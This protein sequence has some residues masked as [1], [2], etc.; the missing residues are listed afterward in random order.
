M[1]NID[2]IRINL[3]PYFFVALIPVIA[4]TV[5]VYR[6]T[7][8]QVNKTFKI[9]LTALRAIA[10]TL[11]LFFL[12]EP[13]VGVSRKLVN[14]PVNLVFVDDS[15]SIQIDDKTN[16]KEKL[17]GFVNDAVSS[18][19]MNHS[20]FFRFGNKIKPVSADSVK[21]L[22][23]S[24]PVTNFSNLFSSIKNYQ[25][26][27]SSIIIISDGVITDGVNPV[28]QAQKTGAPVFTVG[29]GDSTRKNNL[30]I[31]KV[32]MNEYIYA[33]TP[34]SINL[35]I[36]NYGFKNQTVTL[37]F[38]EDNKLLEKQ[39]VTLTGEEISSI[40]F[41]YLPKNPGEKKLTFQLSDLK[42]ESSTADNKKVIYVN[43]LNNKIR[44]LVIAGSPSA[45]LSF[46]KQTL[47]SD[48][49]LKVSSITQIA[50]DRFLENTDRN[51][52]IDSSDVLFL[53]GFPSA[54]TSSSLLNK[55]LDAIKEKNKPYFI[56]LSSGIDYSKLLVLQPELPFFIKAFSNG[57]SEVQSMVSAEQMDNPLLKSNAE[58]ALETWNNL[59]P[60]N[61]DNNDLAAKPE[62]ETISRLKINNIPMN[63]PL[64]VSRKL[65][66]KKSI[67]VLAKDIWKWKLQT[68]EKKL[69]VFDSFILN[70][71]KWMNTKE[72]QKT[73]SIKLAKK[74][75]S[76]GE[77]IEFTAEV[78]NETFNPVDDAE[79]NV[80]AKLGNNNFT[81]EMNSVGNG[82]YEGTL[83]VNKPGDYSF[84]GEA[85]RNGR[86]LGKDAGKF[87]I[88]EVDIEFV[89]TRMDKEFLQELSGETN[90][91]FFTVDNYS[92]LFD[93]V[94]EQMKKKSDYT[95]IKSE[96]NLWSNEWL[97]AAAVLL[98]G[99]EWFFR[100]RSGML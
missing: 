64:I 1:F 24:E 18:G 16:R 95:I 45:D 2:A 28:Y 97:L 17:L 5:Y 6:Y 89:N 14:E 74:I 19:I 79:L 94:K 91:K 62:S 37:S 55:V 90:G 53:V 36:G 67:A 88:G 4:Y 12:F 63:S 30:E 46:I 9:F 7:I 60:I 35:T 92:Q 44:T 48:E 84:Y 100:K 13:V 10:L 23:F 86:V 76:L 47:A 81:I 69:N 31:K 50:Q 78:Y 99:L 65:G 49:N 32:L 66:S 25:K 72:D 21:L 41:D 15:K 70:S 59:P 29:V 54:Q 52:L 33:E 40:N 42:G 26:N 20:E 11:V 71:L 57:T 83:N 75:F 38:Y 43:I 51:S 96:Y 27:I 80:N 77:Q 93:L 56:V 73:V 3:S 58:N 98:F 22:P 61:K 34:T 85:K 39:N 82:I 87:T 8:P 68:A